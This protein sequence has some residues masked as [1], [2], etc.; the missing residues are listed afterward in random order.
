MKSVTQEVNSSGPCSVHP[1]MIWKNRILPRNFHLSPMLFIRIE[2]FIQNRYLYCVELIWRFERKI[3]W[4]K[5]IA[6]LRESSANVEQ[7][8]DRLYKNQH[9]SE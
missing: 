6:L 2:L 5:N 1:V 8:A 7:A 4:K 9:S 3:L